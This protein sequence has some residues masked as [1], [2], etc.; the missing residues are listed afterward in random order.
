M[1]S[2]NQ[3]KN[4]QKP[5][6]ISGISECFFVITNFLTKLAQMQI[7]RLTIGPNFVGIVP[8]F[9]FCP[10]WFAKNPRQI[11]SEDLPFLENTTF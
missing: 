2:E 10:S 3:Y 5:K 4:A 7:I 1:Q 11:Q 8:I 6:S 9:G